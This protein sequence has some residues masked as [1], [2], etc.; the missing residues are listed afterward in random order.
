MWRTHSAVNSCLQCCSA[1]LPSKST[2]GL[3]IPSC[4]SSLHIS[5]KVPGTTVLSGRSYCTVPPYY[6]R[7]GPASIETASVASYHQ[8]GIN[9]NKCK[10]L[11]SVHATSNQLPTATF[12]QK[13]QILIEKKKKRKTSG[14][15][16]FNACQ[17]VNTKPSCILLVLTRYVVFSPI[18]RI[19]GVWF[20]KERKTRHSSVK[21][22]NMSR[23]WT[24]IGTDTAATQPIATGVCSCIW[25]SSPST[26]GNAMVCLDWWCR[27]LY[28]RRGLGAALLSCVGAVLAHHCSKQMRRN[29]VLRNY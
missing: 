17:H 13:H 24:E 11:K 2:D 23:S 16:R 7:T 25:H 9:R 22:S 28:W 20:W 19:T 21:Y 26:Q 1:V 4:L 10:Q 29:R 18:T 15:N 12:P 27:C 5:W 8:R 6:V 3:Q 14:K